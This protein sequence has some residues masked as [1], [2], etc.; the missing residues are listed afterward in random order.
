MNFSQIISAFVLGGFVAVIS[1]PTIAY[2][3]WGQEPPA[4]KEWVKVKFRGFPKGMVCS[5]YGTR[6]RVKVGN[7]LGMPFVK[8]SGFGAEGTIFCDL[9]DG[10]RIETHIHSTVLSMPGIYGGEITVNSKGRAA[11]LLT[12][13]RGVVKTR[14]SLPNAYSFVG[15]GG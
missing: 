13:T 2:A 7:S 12:S 10:R 8:I 11:G 5:A 6:G 15:T 3:G 1:P 4:S 9:P 14:G